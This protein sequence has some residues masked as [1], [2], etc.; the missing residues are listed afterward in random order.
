[1]IDSYGDPFHLPLL[2]DRVGISKHCPSIDLRCTSIKL[3][4]VDMQEEQRRSFIVSFVLKLKG[5]TEIDYGLVFP[6]LL[7][8]CTEGH[9]HGRKREIGMVIDGR[10]KKYYLC[11]TYTPISAV[12]LFVFS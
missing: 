12:E 3:P 11:F 2:K 5:L 8:E 4:E 6:S 1:M 7:R 9:G 10:I